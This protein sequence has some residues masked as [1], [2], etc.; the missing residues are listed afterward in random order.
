M[1][2]VDEK[3]TTKESMD[4]DLERYQSKELKSLKRRYSV[5]RFYE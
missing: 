4:L 1:P 2:T 3:K 5:G